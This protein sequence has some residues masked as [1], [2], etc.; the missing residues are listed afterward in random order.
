MKDFR[1]MTDFRHSRRL[2]LQTAAGS[3]MSLRAAPSDIV[4]LGAIGLGGRGN[5]LLTQEIVRTPYARVTHLCDVDQA[6]LEKAQANAARAGF[7]S[8]RGSSDLRRVLDDKEVDAVVIATPDH[9]HGPATIL[10]CAAG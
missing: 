5:A 9:W 8:V 2:F 10:A 4:R 6:R 3:A 1:D 7:G